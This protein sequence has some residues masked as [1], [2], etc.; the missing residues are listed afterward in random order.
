MENNN[1]GH[2]LSFDEKRKQVGNLMKGSTSSP[3]PVR[4]APP[5]P[6]QKA[7]VEEAKLIESNSK[8]TVSS[9]SKET[10]GKQVNN[11]I[12][13]LLSLKSTIKVQVQQNNQQQESQLK[14]ARSETKS[15]SQS[16]PR[17]TNLAAW[18]STKTIV[19]VRDTSDRVNCSY[20]I[21]LGIFLLV[22]IFLV[23]TLI[24]AKTKK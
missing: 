23:F 8:K 22:L 5:P 9:P 14:V 4:P 10:S 13:P 15:A 6:T 11:P 21:F 20:Y 17:G 1:T 2:E 16:Q 24:L 7:N 18:K 19:R 3:R 12:Q